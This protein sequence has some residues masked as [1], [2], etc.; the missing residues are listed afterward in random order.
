[1]AHSTGAAMD[2]IN[3]DHMTVKDINGVYITSGV[4]GPSKAVSSL[5][6]F[7]STSHGSNSLHSIKVKDIKPA[8][9]QV[10]WPHKTRQFQNHLMDSR[11]WDHLAWREGDVVIAT[12]GK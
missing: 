11:R 2:D 12:W 6:D 8:G 9:D 4:D 3:I 1:M 7:Q 10:V 5:N